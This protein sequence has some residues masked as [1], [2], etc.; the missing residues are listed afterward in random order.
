MRLLIA[1]TFAIIGFVAVTNSAFADTVVFQAGN[2]VPKRG[3][4][5][6]MVTCTIS[7]ASMEHPVT[8]TLL[9]AR[10]R[11]LWTWFASVSDPPFILDYS[12]TLDGNRVD[13]STPDW[14]EKLKVANTLAYW[15]KRSP[16]GY[17]Q[18]EVTLQPDNMANAIAQCEQ[19][20]S[21]Y[22]KAS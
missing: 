9:A 6:G 21:G 20:V 1:A 4:T 3:T 13:T 15:G 10:S 8:F 11:K 12:I 14:I 19:R 5:T 22:L 2:A 18:G 17:Y 7:D 16:I